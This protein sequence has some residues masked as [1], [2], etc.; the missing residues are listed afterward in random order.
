MSRAMPDDQV[1]DWLAGRE[2][3]QAE[4]FDG[5]LILYGQGWRLYVDNPL[6]CSDDSGDAV[7][8]F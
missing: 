7:E 4:I 5:S 3:E 2:I 1:A 6:L 8:A